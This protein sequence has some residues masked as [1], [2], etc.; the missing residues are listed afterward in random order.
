M[1]EGTLEALVIIY[2]IAGWIIS[3]FSLGLTKVDQIG[4]LSLNMR[5][6]LIH[7][8]VIPV[9][10]LPLLIVVLGWRMSINSAD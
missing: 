5:T 1:G 3:L 8:V 10:W 9:A 4:T 2:Y 7:F 6:A